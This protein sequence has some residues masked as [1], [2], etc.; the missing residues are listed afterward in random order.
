MFNADAEVFI[1]YASRDRDRVVAIARCL[2]AQGV[3]VWRDQKNIL[4]GEIYG[5]AIVRGIRESKVL[6]LMCSD[7]SL[8]SRN[9]MQ[10]S[11]LAWNLAFAH[12]FNPLRFFMPPH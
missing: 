10:E 5:P 2:E 8:R 12:F 4:G 9:V 11:L 7:A 3:P 6:M 1:S